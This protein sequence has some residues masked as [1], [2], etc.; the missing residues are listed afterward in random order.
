MCD[1][2]GLLLLDGWSLERHNLLL[3]H[4][5][6]PCEM[7]PFSSVTDAMSDFELRQH[8]KNNPAQI[9]LLAS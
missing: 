8:P 7:I 2:G 1:A 4:D 6:P 5:L 3:D 9:A